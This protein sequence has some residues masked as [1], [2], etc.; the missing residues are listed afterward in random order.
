MIDIVPQETA[1]QGTPLQKL[2]V[3]PARSYSI[4]AQSIDEKGQHFMLVRENICMD[5][6]NCE[7]L[8]LVFDIFYGYNSRFS[9]YLFR[10]LYLELLQFLYNHQKLYIFLKY[11]DVEVWQDRCKQILGHFSGLENI[12]QGNI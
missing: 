12:N 11:R 6:L 1:G 4:L 3:Y 5:L 7:L 9:P 10:K 8:Q 2:L